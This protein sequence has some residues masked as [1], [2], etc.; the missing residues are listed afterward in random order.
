[1]EQIKK[2]DGCYFYG[3]QLCL[4]ADDA[5]CKFR[6]DY[7]ASLG[8]R[9]YRRLN[10]KDR[11][12]RI[13]GFHVYFSRPIQEKLDAEFGQPRQRIP[14]RMLGL[15]GVAYCRGLSGGDTPDY[16]EEKYERWF[17][18]F[19]SHGGKI[20]LRVGKNEKVGRTSNNKRRYR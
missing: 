7:H 10:A 11:S 2:R 5:Y 6:D 16:D 14:Y 1:M 18:W 4:N 8:K 12:E 9:V 19:L 20:M 17:D 3:R 13:H 15:V